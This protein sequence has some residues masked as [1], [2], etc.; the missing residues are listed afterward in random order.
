MEMKSW[1]TPLELA[2]F[3]LVSEPYK[4][5]TLSIRTFFILNF[6]KRR[7]DAKEMQGIFL[8]YASH[9]IL[10]CALLRT[11]HRIRRDR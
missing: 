1:D 4:A 5:R 6:E 8:A 7:D 11:P 2:E 10:Q 3:K 9:V